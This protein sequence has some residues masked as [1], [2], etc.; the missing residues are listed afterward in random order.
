M[1]IFKK[2]MSLGLVSILTLSMAMGSFA[3]PGPKWFLNHEYDEGDIVKFRGE[4]FKAT[5]DHVSSP[6]IY[7]GN[8]E[9]WTST[10]RGPDFKR[11]DDLNFRDGKGNGN[12]D[13]FDDWD[14]DDDDWDDDKDD[15]RDDDKD[16][17]PD[18]DSIYEEDQ[19]K[20]YFEIKDIDDEEYEAVITLYNEKDVPVTDWSLTFELENDE[21]IEDVDDANYDLDDDEITFTPE[22]DESIIGPKKSVS[23][24]LKAELDIL[25]DDDDDSDEEEELDIDDID[26]PTDFDLD[27]TFG[28]EETG[29]VLVLVETPDFDD[30]IF[31]PEVTIGN[32]EKSID[33]GE[34]EVF[35][36]LL[37]GQTY[38][39]EAETYKE[40]GY[41]YKPEIE[42]KKVTVDSDDFELVIISYE[43]FEVEDETGRVL[44]YVFK[45][46]FDEDL[47]TPEITI[48]DETETIEWGSHEYFD[49]ITVGTEHDVEALTFEKDGKTYYPEFNRDEV[50][51]DSEKT[52][53][54]LIKYK[55]K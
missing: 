39:V 6:D 17:E 24:E 28:E 31:E 27:L 3:D 19:V 13:K 11:D 51:V 45:P 20:V 1:K 49:D 5:E 55:V 26:L 8:E 14:D 38:E 53:Y 47:F 36:E 21:V 7:P 50:E 46:Q 22:E 25:D 44:V 30:D 40:D 54:V 23:F 10:G 32:E 48:E 29:A 18:M 42:N 12:F 35:D 41:I 4:F 52:S 2:I 34:E 15:D 9:Y 33:W 37:V 43:R 16:E